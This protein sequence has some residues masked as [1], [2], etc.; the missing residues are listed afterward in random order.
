MRT[1]RLYYC[2]LKR[3][4]GKY[5][6]INADKKCLNEQKLPSDLEGFVKTPKDKVQV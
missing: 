4:E 2:V 3:A 5:L 1:R 6:P